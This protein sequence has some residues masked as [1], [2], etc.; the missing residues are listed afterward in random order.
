MFNRNLRYYRLKKGFSKKELASRTAVSS[1]AISHY[2]AGSRRPDMDV[3]KR[4]AD[5]LDV[6]VSDFLTVRNENL[7][8][9]HRE[10]RKKTALTKTQ[11]EY[12][13]ESVEEYLSRF[14]TVI[15]ILGGEILPQS[16]VCH[17]LDL[18]RDAE[19]DGES[20]RKHLDL[21]S[22][23]PVDNLIEVLEN[24]GILVYLCLIENDKFSGM[25]GFVNGR[26]YIILN[27]NMT[28]ERVRSTIAHEL[29]HLMFVWPEAMDENE[30]EKAAT[31]IG[32][33]FLFPKGD[34]IREL[35]VGRTS[36]G[37][38]MI[39]VAKEYGISMFMLVKRAKVSGIISE[40]TEQKFYIRASCMGW[41]TNEPSRVE[42][43]IPRLFEQLVL[44]AVSEGE[45]S[46]QRAAELLKISYREIAER[47]PFTGDC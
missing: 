33:A 16:P 44:R 1:M 8:F 12:A 23:G 17:A 35:G 24:K 25:N 4:L 36:I 13:K 41:R 37:S 47:Y 30:A 31:A 43:E 34:A 46:I 9:H 40:K 32:G 42:R 39:M 45:I 3:L 2:E 26:P 15:E 5:A 14:M 38:D 21:V 20:L 29:A 7:V 10:F 18:S 11:Q 27:A 19:M 6:R 28:A 22:S